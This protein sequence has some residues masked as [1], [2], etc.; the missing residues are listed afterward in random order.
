[1]KQ[2][3][4]I[5]IVAIVVIV[6]VFFGSA[7]YKDFKLRC[8][9]YCSPLHGRIKEKKYSEQNHIKV[10]IGEDWIFLGTNIQWDANINVGDSIAKDANS[11][12]TKLIK[13]GKELDI[14]TERSDVL[15]KKY[16]GCN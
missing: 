12:T 11:Y 13:D 15:L 3:Q 14:S 8:K 2:K 1:M 10:L 9:F 6:I 7:F 4:T 16:C 5:L